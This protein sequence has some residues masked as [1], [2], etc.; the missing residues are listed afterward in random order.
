ML[1]MLIFSVSI[2][3][4]TLLV[5]VIGL[6]LLLSGKTIPA[7]FAII[8]ARGSML[9]FR[10][11]GR[12]YT[13]KGLENLPKGA[14]IIASQ[15]QSALETIAYTDILS[16]PAYVLKKELYYIPVYGWYLARTGMVAIDRSAKVQALNSVMA[17]AETILA[18]NRKMVIFP[19][20]TRVPIGESRPYNKSIYKL[21]QLGYPVIPVA[22]NSGKIWSKNSI[23]LGK[24]K[25]VFSFLKPLPVGLSQAD[26]MEQL[27][28][29]IKA[30]ASNL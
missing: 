21:Y 24:G 9:C 18:S 25:A 19:E 4:W 5:G 11:A 7:W 6:P 27:Q 17:Q 10:L 20:G 16:C 28:D 1:A 29:A 26:F 13:Y 30:E 23:R 15:H 14:C 3:F 2:G 12:A 22:L 8:W